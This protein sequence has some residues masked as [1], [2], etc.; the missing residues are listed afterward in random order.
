MEDER[1]I[2]ERVLSY[3]ENN[4]ADYASKTFFAT[5]PQIY[6]EF[7]KHVPDNGEILDVGCDSGRDLIWF[8]K[9]GYSV[10]GFDGS[11]NM[12]E[13]AHKKTGLPIIHSTFEKFTSNTLFDA[14]WCCASLLHLPY[15]NLIMVMTNLSLLLKPNA[16]WYLS[17]KYGEGVRWDEDRFYVDFNEHSIINLLDRIDKVTPSNIWRSEEERNNTSI[18]WLNVLV[19]KSS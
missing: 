4:A 7:L 16:V 3:Y 5:M 9:L 6:Q 1:K 8:R 13:V 11:S 10:T 17:F 19:K 15:Q 12:V 2:C 18:S 14:I